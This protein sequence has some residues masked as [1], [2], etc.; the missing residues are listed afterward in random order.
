MVLCDGRKS[1]DRF[2]STGGVTSAGRSRPTLRPAAAADV[3]VAGAS[4]CSFVDGGPDVVEVESE[5]LGGLW[6][7]TTSRGAVVDLA[8]DDPV[9]DLADEPPRTPVDVDESVELELADDDPDPD[10]AEGSADATPCPTTT[11]APIPKAT[12][13]PPIRPAFVATPM[14]DERTLGPPRPRAD[15]PK[16][17]QLHCKP[18]RLSW[19]A[20]TVATKTVHAQRNQRNAGMCADG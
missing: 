4:E 2:V 19:A 5:R 7:D 13:R 8:A 18:H 17:K 6:L 3:S 15:F 20:A 16:R 10:S 9:D 1:L 14:D 12:A 11:A